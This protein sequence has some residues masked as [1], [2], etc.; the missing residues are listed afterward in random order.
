MEDWFSV[1]AR[2]LLLLKVMLILLFHV[3]FLWL[4]LVVLSVSS[5]PSFFTLPIFL[6]A[7]AYPNESGRLAYNSRS[8]VFLLYTSAVRLILFFRKPRSTPRF[9]CEVVSHFNRAFPKLEVK[10]PGAVALPNV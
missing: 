9:S 3:N 6:S 1:N 10:A 4:I 7:A 5:S 8:F 2:I